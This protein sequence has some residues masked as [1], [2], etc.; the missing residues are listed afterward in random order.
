MK[1]IRVYDFEFNLLCIMCDVTSVQWHIL[2]DDVGTFEGHFS[3]NDEISNIILSHRYIVITQGENQAICTGKIV[4]NELIVCGRT[5]NWIL[6]KR[7]R[8]PFKSKDIFGENYTDPETILLYCLEKGFTKPPQIDDDGYEIADSI[9]E[10]KMVENFIIPEKAGA[11]KLTSHFWRISAN[12]LTKLCSDLCKK[13]DRGYRVVFDVVN[14]QWVFEFIY[15]RLN[16]ILISTVS[17]TAYD[18]SY[19]EDMLGLASGGWY[20]VE[21][22]EEDGSQ[23]KWHYIKKEDKK[24]IY[25]WDCVM[26]VSGISE[27]ED[28][29]KKK[30]ITQSVEAKLRKLKYN[31]DYFMGDII[32]VYIKLGEYELL[33]NYK[34]E[35]IDIQMSQNEC[36]EQPILKPLEDGVIS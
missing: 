13:L 9:D 28:T 6:S 24:G 23:A 19:T 8:P 3:L 26:N 22:T 10:D 33:K 30:K 29:L 7:V 31:R 16:N 35:G 17:K 15:S 18:M 27:A 32:P 21:D 14:R 5:V 2:Y 34:V 20:F 11:D 1:D 36:Y 4:D 25:A 12:E